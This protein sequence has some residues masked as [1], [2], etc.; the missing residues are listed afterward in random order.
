MFWLALGRLMSAGLADSPQDSLVSSHGEAKTSSGRDPMTAHAEDSAVAICA[1]VLL[2]QYNNQM[3]GWQL[4]E[5]PSGVQQRLHLT[6]QSG[7][8]PPVRSAAHPVR[9][10]TYCHTAASGSRC[11]LQ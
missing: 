10:L 11:T 8:P 3:A 4:P 5:W 6:W 1:A 9:D 2:L 7:A